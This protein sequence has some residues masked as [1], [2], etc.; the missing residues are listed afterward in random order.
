MD[1]FS[2]SSKLIPMKGLS[3]T[4]GATKV[5]FQ[6]G[7]H[8]F[9]LPKDILSDRGPK[10]ISRVWQAFFKLLG[11]TIALFS[12]Y[13]IQTNGQTV[14]KI[15]EIRKYLRSYC[16]QDQNSWSWFF[17]WT[18]YAQNSLRQSNLLWAYSVPVCAWIPTTLIP[19]VRRAIEGSSC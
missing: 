16:H 15:Q 3:T 12:R 5:L 2:K 9:G 6:N 18:E 14:R 7:F 4:F 17:P 8:H 10:L 1:R 19:M 11:I 13:H